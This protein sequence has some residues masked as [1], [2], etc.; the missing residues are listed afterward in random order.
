MTNLHPGKIV[1]ISGPSGAGKTTVVR[2]LFELMPGLASSVSA[3]T[4]PP[5][6]GEIDG[7]DYFFLTSEEFLRRREA[8][9]FLESCEVFGKGY[10]Y[11]TLNEQ[12]A[13]SLLAGKSVILE[14][15]VEGAKSVAA[16]YPDAVTIF[17]R[18]DS[19]EELQRRLVARGTESPEAVERR[20]Q[21][22]GRELAQS[23]W[24]QHRVINTDVDHAVSDVVRILESEG[25]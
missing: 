18:P 3:T 14:V 10:W 2:R 5:R 8:G 9:D 21:A 20:M 19:I 23:D 7:V 22:A 6:P 13:P 11:G 17:L 1:V 15:D 25:V 12:V 4:R 16:R 24:Y